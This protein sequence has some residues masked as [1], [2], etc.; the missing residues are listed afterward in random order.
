MVEMSIGYLRQISSVLIR[1]HNS[2]DEFLQDDD[3]HHHDV[4][5][6]I[7]IRMTS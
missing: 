1:T 6:L 7:I 3:D 2:T 4:M 5:I